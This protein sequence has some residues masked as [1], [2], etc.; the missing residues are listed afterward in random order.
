MGTHSATRDVHELIH[1]P[2]DP[3][4]PAID[5]QVIVNPAESLPTGWGAPNVQQFQSSHTNNLR[6]NQSA[7]QGYG[8][9]PERQWGHYPHAENP[10]PFRRMIAFQRDGGDSYSADVYRPE[11]VAYWANALAHEQ[12]AAPVKNAM[13]PD[14]VVNQAPSVPYV[15]AIP[16]LLSPGGY[17][18]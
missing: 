12:A 11:V 18:G 2:V 10:N 5:A 7:E 6:T 14:P 13:R 16:D 17:F 4:Y 9:G 8:V 3:R 1:G 15:Q